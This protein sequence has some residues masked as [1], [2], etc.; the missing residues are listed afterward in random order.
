LV[1]LGNSNSIKKIFKRKLM[2]KNISLNMVGVTIK[3][4]FYPWKNHSFI[5]TIYRSDEK[6]GT[7]TWIISD[8]KGSISGL[9]KKLPHYGKY[10]YLVFEGLSLTNKEKGSWFSNPFGLQKVFK[11]N[12]ELRLPEQNP[13]ISFAPFK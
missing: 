8:S 11:K 1:F 13:L 4:K 3:E 7:M 5:F 12:Q 6:K 10:G 9:K 2:K